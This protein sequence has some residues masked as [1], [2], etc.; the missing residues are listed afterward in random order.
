MV[1]H[2]WSAMFS[3]YDYGDTLDKEPRCPSRWI[4]SRFHNCTMYEEMAAT[5]NSCKYLDDKNLRSE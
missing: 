3:G 2:T 4:M 5:F 1:E